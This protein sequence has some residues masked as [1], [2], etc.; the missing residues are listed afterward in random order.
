MPELPEVETTK[1]GLYP[2]IVG[3]RIDDVIIRQSSLRLPIPPDL[4]SIAQGEVIIDVTR[5]SK[6]L[7]IKLQTHALIIHLGMSGHLRI[8][9][10]ESPIRKHD[11]IELHLSNQLI[12]RYNDPRRFGLWQHTSENPLQHRLLKHLGPEPLTSD[13]HGDYLFSKLQGKKKAIKS[14]IMD[15]YI[16][17]GVGNIYASESLFLSGIHPATASGLIKK[18]T[19]NKLCTSIKEILHQAIESGGTTL[20]DFYGA[21]GKP[22]YF[23]LS[24]NVYGRQGLPCL[25]CNTTIQASIIGGRRSAYCPSCQV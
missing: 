8:D 22:G 2:H 20:K 17:V 16:V 21:D 7:I 10:P 13:F 12:L 3:Q 9:T 11:H 23:A 5:R 18:K 19:C 14:L 6:Y 1:A 25:K 15:N 24:L 4:K